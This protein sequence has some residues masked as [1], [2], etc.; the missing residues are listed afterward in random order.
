MIWIGGEWGKEELKMT[1]IVWPLFYGMIR[2]G[3]PWWL[4]W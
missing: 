4:R 2:K 1:L 3:L